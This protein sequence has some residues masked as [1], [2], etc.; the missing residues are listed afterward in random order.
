MQEHNTWKWQPQ[1][2]KLKKSMI[3]MQLFNKILF[4]F[5]YFN[6]KLMSLI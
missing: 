4:D 5:F 3:R 1:M 6:I 2:P